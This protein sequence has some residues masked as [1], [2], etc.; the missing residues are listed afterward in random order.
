MAETKL[1]KHIEAPREKVF[2]VTTDLRKAAERIRG[3]TRLE[4]LTD[5][6][7]GVGTRF[8]ETRIMFKRECTEQMEITSFDRP[9]GYAV[10]CESHGCRYLTEF[11][12]T[13][14]GSG[15]D[16]EMTFRAE[17]LTFFAKAMTF[18]M[19]PMLRKKLRQEMEKDLDDL[20][21]WLEAPAK[22]DTAAAAGRSESA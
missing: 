9:Q 5:G 7:I 19:G 2:D 15:T 3:I 4:V 22:P 1:K 17:P 13:P 18:L 10:G 12:Y 16:V 21:A 8:R 14:A 11:R 20:K 6:P